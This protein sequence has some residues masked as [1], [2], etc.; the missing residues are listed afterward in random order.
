MKRRIIYSLIF[1]IGFIA[2]AFAYDWSAA[3]W[4]VKE[5]G[6]V[7]NEN[8]LILQNSYGKEIKVRY[9]DE[10]ADDLA[11]Q[12]VKVYE[13]FQNWKYMKPGTIEFFVN[14]STLEI[15]VIPSE[16]NYRGYD[17]LPNIPGGM[18][19]ISDYELRYNFRVTKDEFFLR[20]NDRFI[21]EELLCKRMKEAVD[22]PISY[23]KKREPE[24]FLAKL[25]ELEEE[26]KKLLNQQEKLI[27]AVLYF[28]NTGF[29]GFG[30]DQ[31]KTSVVKRVI[32]LKTSDPTLGKDKIKLILE[33]EKIEVSDKE[34][35]LILNI[36][37]NEFK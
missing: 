17:F 12:V 14:G 30:N 4:T 33:K 13:K 8:F 18:T 29:L 11:E 37:Y 9:H 21:D 16:F 1:I 24:Y 22:D 25:N 32:E 35:E 23:L 28:Q 7:E 31:I 10:L 2:N 34:I 20:L 19:F 26:Q 6:T 15:L 36:F 3:G 5:T 27:N